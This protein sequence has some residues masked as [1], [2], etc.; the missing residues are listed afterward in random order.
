MPVLFNRFHLRNDDLKDKDIS[1]DEST[2]KRYGLEIELIRFLLKKRRESKKDWTLIDKNN[3]VSFLGM[4]KKVCSVCGNRFVR[5]FL[6]EFWF[7]ID[8]FFPGLL[9]IIIE[10]SNLKQYNTKIWLF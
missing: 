3:I 10:S 6:Y 8:E 5:S 9:L 1:I 4:T 7:C 2:F